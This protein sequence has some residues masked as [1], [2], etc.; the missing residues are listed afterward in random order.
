MHP[1]ALHRNYM[2]YRQY[3]NAENRNG[4]AREGG[5][6]RHFFQSRLRAWRRRKMISALSAMDE[7]LLRDIGIER[8]RIS[9][10]VDGLDD[11]ELRMRPVSQPA[12][13]LDRY[14]ES[15]LSLHRAA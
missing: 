2:T 7:R 10:V 11:R 3:A 12:L 15:A 8:G 4:E 1:L 9:E 5:L 13:G 6:L 14:R